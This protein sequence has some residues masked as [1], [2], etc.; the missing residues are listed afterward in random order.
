MTNP[1]YTAVCMV[2]DRSG[3]MAL[4]ADDAIGGMK[5]FVAEQQALPGKCTLRT[6][7]F[8]SS[9]EVYH[10]S[11]DIAEVPEPTLV[12]RGSTALYDAFGKAITEFGEELAAMDEADRP[13]NVVF[14]VVT[15]GGEN[16]SREWTREKV[17]E[18]VT[19]QTDEYGWTF[20]YLGA[21]QDAMAV[22][23][24]LGVNHLNT[25]TYEPTAK[26]NVAAYGA[27]SQTVS[28]IRT[29][30]KGTLNS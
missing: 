16:A 2:V 3:S 23:T 26:G 20:L 6:V 29:T 19:R 18:A 28:S 30:G 1:D 4:M 8:D 17:F 13:A 21:N 22:G 15:D 11:K 9:Y 12:P 7:H 25:M 5:T 24:S 27:T 10:P 14:V